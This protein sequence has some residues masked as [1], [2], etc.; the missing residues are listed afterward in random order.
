MPLLI[1]LLGILLS[2][3]ISDGIV[4]PKDYPYPDLAKRHPPRY[5]PFLGTPARWKILNKAPNGPYGFR[6]GWRD[7]CDTSVSMHA[8]NFYKAVI[9]QRKDYVF[10]AKDPDYG[11]GYGIG[12]WFCSRYAEL[13][14]FRGTEGYSGF[15]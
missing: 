1:L 14:G 15:R 5:R 3:C 6:V 2:A 7:G 9:I 11:T 12:Y 13:S 8:K 4:P 10:A